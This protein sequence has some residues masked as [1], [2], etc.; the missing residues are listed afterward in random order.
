[1]KEEDS[2]LKPRPIPKPLKQKN[3]QIF[4]GKLRSTITSQDFVPQTE[5]RNR[6]EFWD[7]VAEKIINTEHK[8]PHEINDSTEKEEMEKILLLYAPSYISAQLEFRKIAEKQNA[9]K[10]KFTEEEFDRLYTLKESIYHYKELLREFAHK[11]RETR[12]SE[13]C[14]ELCY[15]CTLSGMEFTEGRSEFLN[16]EFKW[17]VR[18]LRYEFAAEDMLVAAGAEIISEEKSSE[19]MKKDLKRAIDIRV[20]LRGTTEVVALDIKSRK[21]KDDKVV[22]LDNGR[23]IVTPPIND[24]ALFNGTF[25]LDEKFIEEKAE[26]FEET[27]YEYCRDNRIS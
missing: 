19:K 8:T 14:S 9:E 21:T 5:N 12:V 6:F 22:T 18:G 2:D 27:I 20:R 1:M 4:A 16:R 26:D 23:L 15:T 10:E 13:L 11:Y 25:F 24:D 17:L 3:Y 7:E